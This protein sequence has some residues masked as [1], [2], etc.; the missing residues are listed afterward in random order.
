MQREA[1]GSWAWP[2]DRI[3]TLAGVAAP[4]LWALGVAFLFAH[5]P[6]EGATAEDIRAYYREN[7]LDIIAGAWIFATGTL[8]FLWFLSGLRARFHAAEGAVGRLTA[9]S[10]VSGV[11]VALFLIGL[12]STSAGAAFAGDDLTAG[13]AEAM[14]A[15]NGVFFASAEITGV[16]FVAATGA[17]I[18][19]TGVLPRWWGWITLLLG[20]WLFIFPIGWAGLLIGFP[21]WVLVTSVLLLT[22]RAGEGP[23]DRAVE[24]PVERVA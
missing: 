15:L 3:G 9:L 5:E 7:D 16:A 24:T 10:F 20:L 4:I 1:R 11:G 13:V 17:L 12:A 22:R 2:W 14:Y 6:A 18:F 23:A 19:T 21:L 8:L